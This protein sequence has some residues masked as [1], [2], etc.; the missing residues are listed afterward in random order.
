M[1]DKSSGWVFFAEKDVVAAITLIDNAELTGEVAFHCQQAI[2]KY[3]KAYLA[4]N[5]KQVR[6]I[7]DLVKLYSEIKN[8][9]DWN[10]DEILL[11]DIGKIYTESRY[12]DDIGIKPDGLLPTQ[13]EAQKYLD[14]AK[15]IEN[16]FKDLVR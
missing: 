15:K 12:P 5:D 3:F 6:K 16:L 7:H 1:K 10:I 2:E 8:I 13:E 4:E 11:E 14:F 9:K